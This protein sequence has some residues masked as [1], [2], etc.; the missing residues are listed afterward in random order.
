MYLFVIPEHTSRA[1]CSV[2]NNNNNSEFVAE[3]S[4]DLH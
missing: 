2:N 1:D 4:S 3:I